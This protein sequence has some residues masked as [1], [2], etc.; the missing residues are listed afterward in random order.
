QIYLGQRA[1]GFQSAS[2]VYFGKPLRDINAAEA[3]MLA[4]LPKAPSAYNPIVN[5][6]R[7]R[8]RQEYVLR[9]MN[10]LEYLDDAQFEEA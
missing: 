4:G 3:A 1:Y 8:V 2:Q 6:S 9:R 5:P 7:A 10:D